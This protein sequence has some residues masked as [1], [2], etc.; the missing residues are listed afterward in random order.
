MTSS[1][2]TASY[3][4]PDKMASRAMVILSVPAAIAFIISLNA[5]L[6]FQRMHDDW[7]EYWGIVRE[8]WG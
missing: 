8:D 5:A 1:K 4:F 7:K 6:A 2:K 3:K